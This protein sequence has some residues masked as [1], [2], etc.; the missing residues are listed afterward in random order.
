MILH[1]LMLGLQPFEI[2]VVWLLLKFGKL[3]VVVT[4]ALSI[5]HCNIVTERSAPLTFMTL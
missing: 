2:F 5:A 4:F 1:H 3:P